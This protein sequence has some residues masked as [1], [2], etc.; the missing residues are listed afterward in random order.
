MSFRNDFPLLKSTAYL[1]TAYVGLMSQSLFDH[2][3]NIE[4]DY[5]LNG[6]QF[7]IDAYNRLDQTHQSIANFIGSKREQT[8]LVSNFTI[9]IRYVLDSLKK[10]SN[11]LFL[12]DDYHSLVDAIEE[13]D[14]NHFSIPIEEHLEDKIAEAL[15]Q[16]KFDALIISI[17]QY[18]SGLKINFDFLKSLKDKYPQLLIIGDATQHIGSE[19][20]DFSTSP[21]DAIACSGYKWLLAGF[22]NGFVALSDHFFE[23]TG[24]TEESFYNKVFVG[25]FNTLGAASLVFAM[26]FLKSND[27]EQMVKKN[28]ILCKRLREELLNIG[29]TPEFFKRPSQSSIVS[30]VADERLLKSLEAQNIRASFRGKYLRF[31]FHFYNSDQ[32]I[33]QLISTLK[34]IS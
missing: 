15:A 10:G 27:F 30:I 4:Q 9:G 33:D 8:Y 1:N 21:F 34:K 31:S 2:R 32:D 7:K 6:D 26:D 25:H 24:Q 23:L 16:N 18:T 12:N 22:G 14:F 20:F 11:I 17:V 3:V 28:K 13:R 29:R 5:L 19:L